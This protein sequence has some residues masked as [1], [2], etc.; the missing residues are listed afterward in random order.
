M[1]IEVTPAA[2]KFISEM[3]VRSG[4]ANVLLQLVDGGCNGYEYKWTTTDD[5]TG[6]IAIRLNDTNMLY[7]DKSTAERMYA[8]IISIQP[9]GLNHK[10]SILNPNVRNECGC[11]LSV[12]F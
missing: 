4:K 2:A 9:D 8:S 6:D 3:I 10:L 7:L 1:P 12:S 11:G 5:T